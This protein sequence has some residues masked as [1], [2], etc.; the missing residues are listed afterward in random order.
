MSAVCNWL[1]LGWCCILVSLLCQ[2]VCTE[3]NPDIPY[4]NSSLDHDV[5]FDIEFS[6]FAG[7]SAGTEMGGGAVVAPHP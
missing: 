4:V 1:S 5:S 3:E 7:G 6:L 2:D